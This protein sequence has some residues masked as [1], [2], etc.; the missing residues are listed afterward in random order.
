VTRFL[1]QSQLFDRELGR[2]AVRVAELIA[3]CGRSGHALPI[4]DPELADFDVVALESFL[5]AVER[6]VRITYR[7]TEIDSQAVQTGERTARRLANVVLDA[8]LALDGVDARQRSMILEGDH[9]TA[10]WVL[11]ASTHARWRQVLT[12]AVDAGELPLIDAETGLAMGAR[13]PGAADT[14]AAPAWRLAKLKELGGTVTGGRGA[15]Q[16][17]KI[18]RLANFLRSKGQTPASDKPVRAQ[19]KEFLDEE[20]GRRAMPGQR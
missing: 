20:S 8:A 14:M 11:G 1:A 9:A 12:A 3:W 4:T 19:L 5:C 6:G 17:T 15:W 10:L 16:F 13:A 2:G 7:A 18:D